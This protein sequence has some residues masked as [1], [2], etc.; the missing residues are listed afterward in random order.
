VSVQQR[1]V[2]CCQT[3]GGAAAGGDEATW[4]WLH[5]RDVYI[6]CKGREKTSPDNLPVP[7]ERIA[8]TR[9][10]VVLAGRCEAHVGSHRGSG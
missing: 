5:A 1:S 6:V 7:V 10:W 9:Y 3:H 8:M 2:T 4:R